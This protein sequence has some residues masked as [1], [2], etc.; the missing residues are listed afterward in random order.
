MI[1]VN[2]IMEGTLKEYK[3]TN[4]CAE[5]TE[6][7]L[8]TEVCVMGFVNKRR[9][10]GHLIFISLRDRTGLLQA[11]IDMDSKPELFEKAQSIKP[12]YVIAIKGLVVSRGDKDIN[13]SM[14][15]GKIEVIVSDFIILSEAKTPPFQ[16]LDENVA[17]DL[18]LK[19]RYIDLRRS[20]LQSKLITRHKIS[21]AIR[22]FLDDEGFVE[23]ETPMLTRST[24]EGARDYLVPSSMQKG[25]FY[26]L[27]QSPQVFKQLLMVSGFDKY[28]QIVK[29]FRD[30]DLRADRQPEF[31]QVD[32]EL[33]FVTEKDIMDI[34][35]RLICD[36]MSSVMN[37]EVQRPF[38]RMTY[39]DAMNNYGSDKPDTRF[40]MK[41]I[42]LSDELV[43]C[44]FKVFSDTLANGGCVMGIVADKYVNPARKQLD[45]L[46][47]FVKGYKARGLNYVIIAGDGEIKS[48][49]QK[50]FKG[51]E[52]KNIINV[53]NAQA[54]SI[55]FMCADKKPIVLEALGALRLELAK[56]LDLTYDDAYKFLWVTDFP[57]LEWDENEHR[58]YAKHHPFT[59]PRED[60]F[61]LLYKDP[62]L[63]HSNAYDM[64]LNGFEIGGG[65]IRI[66]QKKLQNKLFE[67]LGMS[68]EEI[69]DKFGFLLEAFNYG[70]PPHGG[71]AY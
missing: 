60:D 23:I 37:V 33:S 45:R 70:I 29:C 56:Q 48:P 55:I 61:D 62:S 59:S 6:S 71:I 2:L 36:I 8:D 68:K 7:I 13:E 46:S 54:G 51:N 38:L 66:H 21:K 52:I 32:I 5:V 31:T 24:P 30:E 39:E 28:Y 63:V 43:N 69:E 4:Y 15:T 10:L 35:E 49:L 53:C 27:P 41:L 44:E 65:S 42:D 58:Y 64:I 34:N 9:N 14:I 19:Y 67:I 50:F 17:N 57:L 11:I 1:E 22:T 20:A 3:R 47:D 16:V 25:K 12:E 18:R 26:A 40:D